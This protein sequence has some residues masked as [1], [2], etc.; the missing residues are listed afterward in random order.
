MTE[1]S[2]VALS[3]AAITTEHRVIQALSD[4]I[5]GGQPAWLCTIIKTWGA[6]PRPAGSILAFHPEHGV[7]GSLSGGCIE[8]DLLRKLADKSQ[9]ESPIQSPFL[10]EYQISGDD[11]VR[12]SLPCGGQLTILVEHIIPSEDNLAHLSTLVDGFRQ[13]VRKVRQ[14]S[15]KSGQMSLSA[16][17]G[18]I[19]GNSAVQLTEE[20][21]RVSFGPAF[22]M[23]L[24]GAGEVSRCVADIANTVDF[25]VTICEPRDSYLQGFGQE[26]VSVVQC[27]PDDLI[28]EQFSDSYCAILALAHDPRVDDMGLMEA[29][30]INAF[31][32]GAVSYTHLTLPT[33][34]IV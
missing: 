33:K 30:R 29:L 32:V 14:V 3:S 2:T 18:V 15:L 20:L 34:R 12:Y 7:V 23:L 27:M 11:Q 6:S 13:R 24:M 16:A 28:R 10:Y 21:M 8:E 22:K 19:E 9:S 5:G 17:S 1:N 25:S 31:Y 26:G 4:W